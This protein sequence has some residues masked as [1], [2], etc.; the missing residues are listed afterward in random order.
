MIFSENRFPL[1]R[2]MLL[3]E[4]DLFA[5]PVPTFPDHALEQS[6]LL[7]WRPRRDE[8]LRRHFHAGQI[9]AEPLASDLEAPPNHPGNRTGAGHALAPCRIVILAAARLAN[10]IDYVAIPVW[11]T[12]HQPFAKQV[13][14]LERQAKKNVAGVT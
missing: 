6:E 12:F 8:M 13:L 2:I 11:K 4:H 7:G 1:F 9:E 10:E 3:I 14:D 5:K